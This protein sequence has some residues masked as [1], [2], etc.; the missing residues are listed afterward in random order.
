M[1]W[2]VAAIVLLVIAALLVLMARTWRARGRRHDAL[3]P[4]VPVPSGLTAPAGSWDGLYV[5][6]TRADAPLDRVVGGGLG[7]RGRG[8]VTVHREGVVLAVTGQPDRFV[9]IASYR[10]AD[11]A[12]WTIDRVVERGGLV[13]LRWSGTGPGGTTDLD[14]YFRFPTG[15]AAPLAALRELTETTSPTAG[16]RGPATGDRGERTR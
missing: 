11:R 7:F 15:D 9:P 8:S 16:D 5:A 12:T 10:G 2:V 4:P 13:R 14:T 3:V 6:T 1:R